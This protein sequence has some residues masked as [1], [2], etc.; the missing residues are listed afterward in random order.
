MTIASVLHEAGES[1]LE[2]K[3]VVVS[4]G[5]ED[6]KAKRLLRFMRDVGAAELFRRQ[7]TPGVSSNPRWRLSPRV[8]A[9]WQQVVLDSAPGSVV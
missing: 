3:G 1:G 4:C 5:M 2:A 9:L 7:L 8:L 6:L